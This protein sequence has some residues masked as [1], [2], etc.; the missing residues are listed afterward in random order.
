MSIVEI[1]PE[2]ADLYWKY[3]L[4]CKNP[5]F[6]MERELPQKCEFTHTCGV[7]GAMNIFRDS[8]QPITLELPVPPTSSPSTCIPNT[9]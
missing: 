3:C 5:M 1:P 7:C 8:L 9:R 2:Y 6:G 4:K